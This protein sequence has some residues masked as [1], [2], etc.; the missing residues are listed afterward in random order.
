MV[1]VEGAVGVSW[2]DQGRVQEELYQGGEGTRL[3]CRSRCMSR[4]EGP[5]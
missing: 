5:W 2:R 3:G 1:G 4:V